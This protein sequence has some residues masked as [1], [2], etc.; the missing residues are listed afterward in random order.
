VRR[1]ELD[2]ARS[3]RTIAERFDRIAPDAGALVTASGE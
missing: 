2:V 3:V 1:V